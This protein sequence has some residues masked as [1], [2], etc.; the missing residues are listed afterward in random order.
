MVSGSTNQEWVNVAGVYQEIVRAL[1]YNSRNLKALNEVSNGFA[2]QQTL[3]EPNP[4][5]DRDAV[6][7]CGIN[8]E[9]QVLVNLD[10]SGQKKGGGGVLV[11]KKTGKEKVAKNKNK[12]VRNRG[13]HE[14]ANAGIL[15]S[16]LP[17]NPR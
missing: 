12:T 14:R 13:G 6:G 17:N 10:F 11:V 2:R 5:V 8:I 15:H 4:T 1:N 16:P 7:Y 3:A 9:R